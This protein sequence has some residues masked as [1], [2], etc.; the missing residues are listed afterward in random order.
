MRLFAITLAV[1]AIDNGL[2]PIT[3][4]VVVMRRGPDRDDER[5]LRRGQRT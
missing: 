2:D 3:R 5:C 4:P 1:A